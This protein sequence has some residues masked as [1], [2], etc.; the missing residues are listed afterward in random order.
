MESVIP[1]STS[2]L[3]GVNSVLNKQ[4][5]WIG[6]PAWER[7]QQVERDFERLLVQRDPH[8][9]RANQQQ[10]FAHI[11][12]LTSFGTIDVKA[13]KRL[14][15]AGSI[16]DEIIWCELKN[17]QGKAGWLTGS[18]DIIAFERDKCFVLVKRA[19]LLELVDNLCDLSNMVQHSK[20]AL[21]KGYTRKGRNDLLTVIKMT[22]LTLI[23]YRLWTK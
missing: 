17:V 10:Q 22:D 14:S 8:F 11:D 23:N 15:R 3:T 12:F 7:G 21:Y 2:H 9:K 18:P 6:S 1:H 4:S 13:K 20:Q 5:K 19:D 16:H